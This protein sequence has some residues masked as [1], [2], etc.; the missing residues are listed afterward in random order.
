MNGRKLH[1]CPYLQNG[2]HELNPVQSLSAVKRKITKGLSYF[3]KV[4]YFW[5]CESLLLNHNCII[6]EMILWP[7]ACI[8]GPSVLSYRLRDG[9]HFSQC[10]KMPKIK[11]LPYLLMRFTRK[12]TPPKKARAKIISIWMFLSQHFN[13]PNI[14]SKCITIV[15]KKKKL[16]TSYQWKETWLRVRMYSVNHS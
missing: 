4:I 16:K 9:H 8:A 1:G 5:L 15:T 3:S 12:R 10:L 7:Q 11:Q 14:L 13:F 2:K 6:S